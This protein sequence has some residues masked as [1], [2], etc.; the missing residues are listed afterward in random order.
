MR[1][2][3]C[4]LRD[5]QKGCIR[6]KPVTLKD[7]TSIRFGSNVQL[8][9][10]GK[11]AAYVVTEGDPDKN[12][13]T[14]D[15]WLCRMEDGEVRR[16][17][18]HGNN[19]SYIWDDEKTLL[20]QTDRK[21]DDKAPDLEE[22]SVFYR[23]RI[24]GGEA[25]KA[26]EIGRT[27]LDIQKA[28][29][30]LYV[31]KVLTDRNRPDPKTTDRKICEEEKDYHI[32][33]EVPFWGNG[34]GYVSGKRNVLYLFR[35]RT[36][37]LLRITD[38]YMNVSSFEVK[39][40]KIVFTGRT[41]KD[42]ITLKS[43]LNVYDIASKKKQQIVRQ[44]AMRVS[45]AAFDGRKIY[46]GASDMKKWGT[47]Q[48]D[49]L[50]CYDTE[51]GENKM[52]F[53]NDEGIAIGDCP[54]SDTFY[55]GGNSFTA[56]DGT[57]YFLAMKGF[58]SGIYRCTENE[59]VVRLLEFDGAIS[60]FDTDGSKFVFNGSGK[61]R[62]NALY[63]YEDD[64]K[65]LEDL[66]GEFLKDRYIAEA[67]Y[68]PFT[69]SDGYQV[70]GW[71]LKPYGYD[72]KK[73]YPAVLEI[74][75]GPRAAYG[76]MFFHEMQTFASAGYFVF[77][78]NP[79]GSEGYG[80]EFADLR[81][82]YGTIDF[83]DLMEFTDHV[84]ASCP[85]IDPAK[86]GVLG[87]SY[88]GF[89]CNWIEGNTDRF[90]AIASQRSVSNWVADF[91]ASEIGVT[92]DS[93]EMA[94]TPWTDMQKMWDQSPLKYACNGKTPILFIHSLQDYNCPLD[95]GLEMFTA[96]KYFKVP[97]RMVVFEGENHN[98]SRTGKPKH[99]IRRL[100]EMHDWFTKYVKKQEVRNA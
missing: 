61:N 93:N 16:L 46:Y 21:D 51:T 7:I 48:L 32:F 90:A 54:I 23:L 36:G 73:K 77:F 88:G 43:S 6:M 41:Y 70:D 15:I 12:G 91:G 11:Y 26:F 95:Q 33:D 39:A 60:C 19:S 35:E 53:A 66:N 84:L 99:R 96:M 83:M 71:I 3:Q 24:D 97:S 20:I 22:K 63:G 80:E 10:D 78:C 47:G 67:E 25:A 49:D 17:T 30:G 56:V 38:Q 57:L 65:V 14:H 29:D 58:R 94:A 5:A 18:W 8:S 4:L 2:S 50:Y 62:L 31:C 13:Y 89:M 37:N 100:R 59:G 52:V 75:G 72:A 68:I 81:G 27:V 9:P 82:K 1:A 55:G 87:G 79:R 92:F 40:G 28:E 45:D 44:T 34:R 76:E 86:L 64:L 98:L 69:D 42:M 74:H 85:Q